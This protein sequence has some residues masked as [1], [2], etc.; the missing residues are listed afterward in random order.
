MGDDHKL[1]LADKMLANGMIWVATQVV[2]DRA[3]ESVVIG[4]MHR[5]LPQCNY[6]NARMLPLLFAAQNVCDAHFTP[7]VLRLR[8]LTAA[9]REAMA[10][11]HDFAIWRMGLA[12]VAH[13]ESIKR[14]QGA[15]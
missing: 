4:E 8:K 13:R 9:R 5:I 3:M 2:C 7:G 14:Q 15:A 1:T 12:Q 11:V 10:C 6:H